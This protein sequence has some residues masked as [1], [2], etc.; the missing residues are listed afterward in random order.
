MKTLVLCVDRD[1]DFGAKAGLNS[2]FIGR[3]ENLNAAMTLG[4]KDAEDSD[5]NTLFAAICL[6][7]EM[8]KKGMSVEIATIC[9]DTDVGYESDL[10]LATQLETVQEVVHPDRVVLVSDGAEDEYIYPMISSRIKV[11]SV[12]KV[13][14]KQVPTVEGTYYILIKM[15]NDDK[16]RKRILVPISLALLVFG[17]FA[18]IDPLYKLWNSDPDVSFT[19]IGLAMIWLVVGM[20]LFSFA[21]KAG[22][23]MRVWMDEMGKAVRSGSQLIPF[24]ILSGLLA[25]LGVLYGWD[26]A[27][28]DPDAELV[29]QF[30]LF[31]STT[32]WMW[33]FAY[34]AYQVGLFINHWLSKGTVSYTFI[35]ASLT[36]F[37]AGFILQGALDATAVFFDYRHYDQVVVIL[38]IAAG[39]LL[40][41]FGGLLNS[42]LRGSS[43]DGDKGAEKGEAA[44]TTE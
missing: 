29:Q 20:Y 32:L 13:Y 23:K 28:M 7:D 43:E 34:F 5:I 35:I 15:L 18:L 42:S 38:E 22:D 26:A 36:V 6:Y 12:R 40:A 21:Y 2:P 3:E 17:L 14:V 4:L 31:S 1:D 37:A 9:G 24:A 19:S 27:T 44:E 16:I 10:V 33:V 11:D 41:V 8:T 30:L 39:F 25:V